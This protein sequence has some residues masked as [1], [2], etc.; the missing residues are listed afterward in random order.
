VGTSDLDIQ[1]NRSARLSGSV[2][3]DS[4]GNRYTGQFR[5][6]GTLN[7]NEPFHY[8]DVLS[9]RGDSAGPGMNYGRLAYQIP[10]GGNGF[11]AGIAASDLQ[12]KLGK[13]FKALGANG[14]AQVGTFWTAYQVVRNPWQ[15]LAVQLSYNRKRLEDRIDST[16][17]DAHK[18]LDVLTLG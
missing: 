4:F 7:F 12:Y 18:S 17:S 3:A 11:K 13:Q 8:G 14:A 1:L 5:G 9:F 15:N 6:G 10:V 16:D 2:D